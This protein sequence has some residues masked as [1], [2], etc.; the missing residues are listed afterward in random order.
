MGADVVRAAEAGRQ[1]TLTT[2]VEPSKTSIPLSP[3]FV[4]VGID[5]SSQPRATA[6][7]VVEW[8]A[9][10]AS[11]QHLEAD[12]ANCQLLPLMRSAQRVGLDAP[13][14]WPH[15]F[16]E[17][18]ERWGADD[19]W[20]LPWDDRSGSPSLRLRATDEWVQQ[21]CGKQP[22][23]V[24]SDR[25]GVTAWRAAALLHE[26]HGSDGQPLDRV[27]GTV[28]EVYPG[29][30][31]VAW[32]LLRTREPISYKR[33]A[34]VR[35]R[36]LD[37]IAGLAPWLDLRGAQD[38]LAASDHRFDAFVCALVARSTASPA[39]AHPPEMTSESRF[40]EEGWIWLPC[41]DSLPRLADPVEPA[42]A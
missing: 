10:T 21:K 30:A 40:A 7:C 32:G 6:A 1:S 3:A 19:E 24:S 20:P 15:D 4:T 37:E 9:G 11:L 26:F 25:I 31:L 41:S 36:L 22:L 29:A 35:R 34:G 8:Q 16:R 42:A 38:A 18:V 23:S 2:V 5:L 14:G 39:W 27:H 17:A 12:L 33:D 13:F 28:R